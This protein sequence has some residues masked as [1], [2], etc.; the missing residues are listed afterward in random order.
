MAGAGY[1][2]VNFYRAREDVFDG[3]VWTIENDVKTFLWRT[4]FDAFLL[5]RKRFSLTGRKYIIYIRKGS[6]CS[7]LCP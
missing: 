3:F 2:L 5:M 1:F 7:I 4:A 6:I